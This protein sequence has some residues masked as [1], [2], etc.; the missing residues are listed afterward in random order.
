MLCCLRRW[1]ALAL[2]RKAFVAGHDRAGRAGGQASPVSATGSAP[3]CALRAT[4]STRRERPAHRPGC[5]V[6]GGDDV[7]TVM[8]SRRRSN[9]TVTA[10][11]LIAPSVSVASRLAL[12]GVDIRDGCSR[13]RRGTENTRAS[14]VFGATTLQPGRPARSWPVTKALRSKAN[15]APQALLSSRDRI[16]QQSAPSPTSPALKSPIAHI[17]PL[18]ARARARRGLEPHTERA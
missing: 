8:R 11:Q 5:N 13:V 4:L 14:R 16:G 6:V 2:L 17:R 12:R 7:G 15:P 18:P 10:R 1:L 9:H 3:G